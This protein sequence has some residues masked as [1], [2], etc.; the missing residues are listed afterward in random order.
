MA[1]VDPNET[2]S[3]LLCD[4]FRSRRLSDAIRWSFNI[5]WAGVKQLQSLRPCCTGNGNAAA[6]YDCSALLA[7]LDRNTEKEQHASGDLK[8]PARALWTGKPW[9]L[10]NVVTRSILTI[11][12]AVAFFWL[13]FSLGIAEKIVLN[14]PIILWTGL[15]PANVVS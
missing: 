12:A 6:F 2:F 9:I 11:V 14:T 3:I 4:W 15:A 8:M 10:P 1:Q 5:Y 7:R 13:E